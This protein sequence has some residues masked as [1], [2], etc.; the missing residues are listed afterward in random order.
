VRPY[1]PIKVMPACPASAE[2]IPGTTVTSN[3]IARSANPASHVAL[4]EDAD[5]S[6]PAVPIGP[7]QASVFPGAEG[8]PPLLASSLRKAA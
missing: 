3:T 1:G 7:S 4:L 6:F 8:T 2:M 5:K